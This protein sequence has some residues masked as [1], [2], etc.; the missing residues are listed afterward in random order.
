MAGAQR[1]R[2]TPRPAVA[3]V[4]LL[5][6]LLVALGLVVHASGAGGVTKQ[7][8]AVQSASLVQEGQDLIWR[9]ELPQPFSPRRLRS[10]DRSVCLLIERAANT[11]V[12]SH[13][14]LSGPQRGT[15]TPQLIYTPGM[16]S[17]PGRAITAT[18]TRPSDRELT[19][20]FLPASIGLAYRPLRWQ[21]ISTV[22]GPGC[23]PATSGSTS[24]HTLFPAKLTLLRLHTPQLVGCV[25]AGPDWVFHGPQR[26]REVALTFDDGPWWE[27]E[28]YQFVSLLARERAP[29]TFFE[30]GEH[31]AAYDPHGTVEREMLADGDMI[32]DHTWSH[33]DLLGLPAVQQREQIARAA[34][35]IRNATAGF[36]PCL[37]R[38]PDGAVNPSLLAVARS[39]GFSTIQWDI[40][41]R[42]WA[43]PGVNAIIDNVIANAHDGAI[44][45]EHYGGGPRYQTL[46][47]LP[48]EMAE[49][50]AKGYQLV[51]LT[52]SWATSSCTAEPDPPV[53]AARTDM[54]PSWR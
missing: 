44:V 50:R 16:A 15:R 2:R 31:I 27:P 20:R 12:A 9:V 54:P 52:Q 36:E 38:A 25:A 37:F 33:P 28:T 45:E 5:S 11:S 4:G 32:G 17:P 53:R 7:P 42:D 26:R 47:A 41:P 1:F 39:M 49:L 24:C 6:A 14:C 30:I 40:D 43:L 13:V 10:G 19:A 29:A 23:V 48:R 22:T 46:E 51:T 21:V 3:R 18:V 35:A 34:A 8:L